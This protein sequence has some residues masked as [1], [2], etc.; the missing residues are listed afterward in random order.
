M[1]FEEL[2]KR[3]SI[4]PY[5]SHSVYYK[6]FFREGII[7]GPTKK[8]PYSIDKKK[9]LAYEKKVGFKP[10]MITVAEYVRQHQGS[11]KYK[12]LKMIEEESIE[13]CILCRNKKKIYYRIFPKG[14]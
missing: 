5:S 9:L 2:C 11:T 12:V 1:T 4:S 13:S 14:K 10:G 6:T 7:I 8:K 3:W